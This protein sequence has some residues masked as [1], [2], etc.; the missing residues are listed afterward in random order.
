MKHLAG[1]YRNKN[2]ITVMIAW[3]HTVVAELRVAG[4]AIEDSH[5]DATRGE[6]T[7]YDP[8]TTRQIL[9]AKHMK[10]GFEAHVTT[11]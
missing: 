6:A 7:I 2:Y 10:R 1:M 11:V 8:T 9:E 5:L 4:K 3:L